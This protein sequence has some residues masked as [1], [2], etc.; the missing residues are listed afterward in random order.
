MRAL[1]KIRGNW[2]KENPADFSAWMRRYAGKEAVVVQDST[3]TYFCGTEA[4]RDEYRT[5]GKN[6]ELFDV[7]DKQLLT[8]PSTDGRRAPTYC[9]TTGKWC[10]SKLP[11][12]L[13]PTPCLCCGTE[14]NA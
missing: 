11:A 7:L 1:R 9:E 4:L 3:K 2:E 12:H 5:G 13:V 10:S 8:L 6:A 14:A